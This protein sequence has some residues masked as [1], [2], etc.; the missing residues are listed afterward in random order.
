MDISHQIK[1]F[2][3]RG[4]S[5]EQAEVIALM[6]LAAGVLFQAFPDLFVLFG[7]ATL[8]LF[9]HSTRSSDD[10][11]LLMRTHN[12]PPR[13]EIEEALR[14]GLAPA[15]EA[16]NLGPLQFEEEPASAHHGLRLWMKAADG[17]KLFRIDLSRFGSV[18][19]S[20]VEEH[21]IELDAGQVATV[22]APNRNHLLLQKA[23]CFLL[24]RVIKV[25]DAFDIWHL[26]RDCGCTL[27]QNLKA[28]LSDTLMSDELEAADIVKRIQQVDERRCKAELAPLIGRQDFAELERQGFQPLRDALLE[29]YADWL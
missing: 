24:R 20:M 25:R 13:A 2:R 5:S 4:F 23:E 27:D 15:A 7:G 28:H 10:L 22:Q 1:E 9:Q 14:I 11:D 8:L 16:L 17:A 26:T 18:L 29:L 6:R 19:S 12:V 21:Q 3:D